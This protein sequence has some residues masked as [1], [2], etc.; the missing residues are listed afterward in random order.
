[1]GPGP[2]FVHLVG[3]GRRDGSVVGAAA[4]RRAAEVVGREVLELDVGEVAVA[5]AAVLG[6]EPVRVAL[7]AR[8][9][10]AG[11]MR[12]SF[13]RSFPHASKSAEPALAAPKEPPEPAVG[14][15]SLSPSSMLTRPGSMPSC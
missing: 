8:L 5:V 13:V 4:A 12:A 11:M 10:Q 14:G 3:L 9:V 7:G 2:S 15:K 6:E 1:M